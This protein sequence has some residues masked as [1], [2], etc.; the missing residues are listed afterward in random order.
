MARQ[1]RTLYSGSG[2]R[3]LRGVDS[4]EIDI[5]FIDGVL[6]TAAIATFCDVNGSDGFIVAV[7]DQQGSDDVTQS[8][9][10]FQPKIYDNV[11]GINL[12]NGKPAALHSGNQWWTGDNILSIGSN[13]FLGVA[14]ANFGGSNGTVFGKTVY[15]GQPARYACYREAGTLTFLLDETPQ[16]IKNVTGTI[17]ANQAIYTQ[18]VIDQTSHQGWVDGISQGTNTPVNSIGMRTTRFLIG[19]YSNSNDSGEQAG[20]FLDGTFQEGIFWMTN[21]DANRTTIESNVRTF[22]GTP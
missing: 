14:V 21:E 3:I 16:T 4:Q 15:A 7:Y 17:S 22:Y 8:N 20:L 9:G 2:I 10:N 13:S 18:Q 5:G 19:A 1:L 11:T 6:D 12:E